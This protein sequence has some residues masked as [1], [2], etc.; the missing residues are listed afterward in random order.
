[1]AFLPADSTLFCLS[2]RCLDPVEQCSE[3]MH[4]VDTLSLLVLSIPSFS[5]VLVF[6]SD[7]VLFSAPLAVNSMLPLPRAVDIFDDGY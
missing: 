3:W 5:L 2:D 6:C 4:N 1:M 7:P